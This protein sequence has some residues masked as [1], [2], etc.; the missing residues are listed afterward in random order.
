[1]SETLPRTLPTQRSPTERSK[2]AYNGSI[3]EVGRDVEVVTERCFL[4]VEIVS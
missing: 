3:T 1:V 2:P 4:A